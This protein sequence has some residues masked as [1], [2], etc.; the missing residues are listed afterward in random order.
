M[1]KIDELCSPKALEAALSPPRVPPY[2][3]LHYNILTNRKKLPT[4]ATTQYSIRAKDADD[5]DDDEIQQDTTQ[6]VFRL[7]NR[8]LSNRHPHLPYTSSH[9]TTRFLSSQWSADSQHN[10]RDNGSFQ[11]A[12]D[13]LVTY[14]TAPP[15]ALLAPS[16]LMRFLRLPPTLKLRYGERT[17]EIFEPSETTYDRVVV[18]L[19][20]GAWGSGQA[21]MYRLIAYSLSAQAAVAIPNQRVWPHGRVEEQVKDVVLTCQ[22]VQAKLKCPVT[23]MGHS[24]GAHIGILALFDQQLP[25]DSFIGLSGPYNVLHHTDYEAGRG[26]EELSPLKPVNGTIRSNLHSN[27]LQSLKVLKSSTKPIPILLAH[28]MEDDTVPFTQTSEVARILRSHGWTAVEEVYLGKTG[29]N[30]VVIQLMQ[31]GPALDVVQRFLENGLSM[32]ERSRRRLLVP[33]KL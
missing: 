9:F 12:M 20:G 31:G 27:S 17:V 16:L 3:S 10:F 24:S 26:L 33:S 19:H 14:I 5:D 13:G 4:R 29:H 30:E 15:L 18:F 28:G 6:L 2:G 23:L 8:N 25:V 7:W 11:A 21:W 32:V 22:L 1:R